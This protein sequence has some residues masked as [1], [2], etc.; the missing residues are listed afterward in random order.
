[1]LSQVLQYCIDLASFSVDAWQIMRSNSIEKD[2]RTL[3]HSPLEEI[4]NDKTRNYVNDAFYH[5]THHHFLRCFLSVNRADGERLR[6]VR[7]A[8]SGQLTSS[9]YPRSV[10]PI[11]PSDTFYVFLFFLIFFKIFPRPGYLTQHYRPNSNA[12]G[13]TMIG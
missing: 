8:R 11:A 13:R 10:I 7:S 6:K 5:V 4:S 2:L 3:A 1:M 12:V 9:E